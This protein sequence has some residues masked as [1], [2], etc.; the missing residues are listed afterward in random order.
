M[1]QEGDKTMN[2]RTRTKRRYD[3]KLWQR[4][5]LRI[6]QLLKEYRGIETKVKVSG[7]ASAG[8]Y[9]KWFGRAGVPVTY[10]KKTKVVTIG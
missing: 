3:N 9:I 6:F 5:R 7:K 8:E 10:D 1:K 4:E 2:N